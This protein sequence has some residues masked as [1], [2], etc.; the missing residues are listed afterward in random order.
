MFDSILGDVYGGIVLTIR[1]WFDECLER[2]C[3]VFHFPP[4]RKPRIHV[5]SP[6]SVC[7]VL[8]KEGASRKD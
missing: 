5:L 6:G 7:L 8:I 3:T 2:N 1:E 4:N